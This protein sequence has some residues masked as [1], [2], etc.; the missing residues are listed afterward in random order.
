MRWKGVHMIDKMEL[1]NKLVASNGEEVRYWTRN[2]VPCEE[3]LNIMQVGFIWKN[4]KVYQWFYDRQGEP[5]HYKSDCFLI[6]FFETPI[7]AFMSA[8]EGAYTFSDGYDIRNGDIQ[9]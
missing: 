1:Y 3:Y 8:L 7:E 6:D 4:N 9:F 5:D 2:W